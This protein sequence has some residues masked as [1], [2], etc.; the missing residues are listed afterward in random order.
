VTWQLFA[1]DRRQLP[2]VGE[3]S[4][5]LRAELPA[6]ADRLAALDVATWRPEV[7]DELMNLRRLALPV[8]PPGTPA[9]CVELAA[10]GLQALSIVDLAREDD[11]GAV[12]AYEASQRWDALTGLERAARRAVVAAGSPE[13]WPS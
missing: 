12:T 3:A 1:A 8:A 4:R 2:D 13:V 10:R 11:G 5:A 9:A 7:A 6:A